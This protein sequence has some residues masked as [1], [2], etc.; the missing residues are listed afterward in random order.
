MP[1]VASFVHLLTVAGGTCVPAPRNTPSL[2]LSVDFEAACLLEPY[3]RA[4]A[5]AVQPSV[6]LKG[7]HPETPLRTAIFNF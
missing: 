1:T 6:S 7:R 3:G 4:L 5:Q 2:A